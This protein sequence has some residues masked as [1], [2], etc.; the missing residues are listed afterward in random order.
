MF[1]YVKSIIYIFV[2][3][4]IAYIISNLFKINL[5]FQ[6]KGTNALY[7]FLIFVFA[8]IFLIIFY[9]LH[10]HIL[11]EKFIIEI[12]YDDSYKDP[13]LNLNY[14]FRITL[15]TKIIKKYY[16][17]GKIKTELITCV[18]T[19]IDPKNPNKEKLILLH[20]QK[21]S[22]LINTIK[23][24]ETKKIPFIFKGLIKIKK[25]LPL[26]EENIIETLEKK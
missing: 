25:N 20:Y 12:T 24:E 6:L 26:I 1:K 17:K 15:Y 16:E 8:T 5:D 14:F 2:I 10:K 9:L 22:N 21:V 13:F 3:F 18:E 19:K 4:L 11:K 7:G 23:L